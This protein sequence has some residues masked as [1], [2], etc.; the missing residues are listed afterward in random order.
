MSVGCAWSLESESDDTIIKGNSLMVMGRH[1]S[2]LWWY[3]GSLIGGTI[4]AF[5][6]ALRREVAQLG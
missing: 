1:L 2:H 5:G 4:S 6:L 3:G